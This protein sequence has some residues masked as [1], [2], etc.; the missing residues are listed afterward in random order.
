MN[1]FETWLKKY[2]KENTLNRVF[3]DTETDRDITIS[4]IG[5]I[6]DE[7]IDKEEYETFG[8]YLA[9]CMSWNGGTLEERR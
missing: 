7:E 8:I 4:E 2:G 3:H 9:C 6:Y 5:K 1:T